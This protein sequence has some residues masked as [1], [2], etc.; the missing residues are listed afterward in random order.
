MAEEVN[1]SLTKGNSTQSSVQSRQKKSFRVPEDSLTKNDPKIAETDSLVSTLQVPAE[2]ELVSLPNKHQSRR[3]MN[4][5][6]ALLSTDINSPN[7]TLA[8][9]PNKDSLSQDGLKVE[10]NLPPNFPL[11][12][13]KKKLIFSIIYECY[14]IPGKARF[15]LII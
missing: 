2:S 6:R 1:R 13:K 9:Q 4:L 7:Y 10:S 12:K 11:A 3:K 15:L 8:N 14:Q 5:K